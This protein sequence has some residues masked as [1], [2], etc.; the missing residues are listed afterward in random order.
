MEYINDITINEAV[1]HILDNN[2]DE[3]ILNEYTLDLNEEIYKFLYKHIQKN[4]AD[5]ELKYALFNKERNIVK[6][7]SQEFL[8][9]ENNFLEISKELARQL[10]I[11][12][13]SKGNIPSCDL[14]LAS[15]STEYGPLLGIIKMDYTKNYVHTIEFIENKIGINIVPQFTGLPTSGQR[16]QKCAFI[17]P[18]REENTFDLMVI[19]KVNKGSNNEEYGSN[20]FIAS[21]LGCTV[22]DN[23]RDMTKNF[24]NSAEKWTRV[25]LKENAE[26]Q[27]NVRSTLKKK[28]REE[29]EIDVK[30]VAE[31]LFKNQNDAKENFVNYLV[32][33]G[34]SEKISVDK[35]WIEKKFNRV[36]LKI[37]K[38]IDL[39]INN[40]TYHDNSKFE[41]IRN[42]DGTINMVIKHVSNYVEK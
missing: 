8:N 35:E 33:Q 9:G 11:L 26:A 36:R 13:R 12:M 38:D 29:E 37:D 6:D 4:L 23:E 17:K 28:L 5:E 1:I 2:S 14:V 21:Y 31:E 39:Y 27:E 24:I 20:Y 19:D 42:G 34:G 41:I 40:E 7:L 18:I 16:I 15:I 25:N 3:P 10:F 32:E 30:E 22:F